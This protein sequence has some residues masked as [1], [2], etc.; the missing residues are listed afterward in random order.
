M[1]YQ[2][3]KTEATVTQ[4]NANV[5]ARLV[6]I[7]TALVLLCQHLGLNPRTGERLAG[8]MNRDEA[9]R[10]TKATYRRDE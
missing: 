4:Y 7:E 9:H 1:K 8:D 2:P 10:P 3:E 6:R 5:E